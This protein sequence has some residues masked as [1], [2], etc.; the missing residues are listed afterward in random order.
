MDPTVTAAAIGVGGTVIVAVTGF[1]ATV[2][3]TGRTI[4]AGRDT[5]IWDRKADVYVDILKAVHYRQANRPNDVP[6]N[7]LDEESESRAEAD[8]DAY[9]E[10]DWDG[11]R[12]RAQA[13]G[14]T[15]V[16]AA[17]QASSNT[18]ERAIGC[19]D[20]CNPAASQT[21]TY[22]TVRDQGL[23]IPPPIPGAADINI[24]RKTAAE[25]RQAADDADA[26]LI[27]TIRGELLEASRSATGG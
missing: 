18:H 20:A 12:A 17:L 19:F 10:P 8:L 3:A 6:T 13:F 9:V 7:P 4:E 27:E 22:D 26:A 14:S 24:A 15:R 16:I 2:R 11:L 21:S 1:W 23:P 25:A 5:R